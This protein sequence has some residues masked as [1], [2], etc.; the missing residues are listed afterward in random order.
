[1]G[2]VKQAWADR[3]EP[4]MPEPAFLYWVIRRT[5]TKTGAVDWLVGDDTFSAE[6]HLREEFSSREDAWSRLWQLRST[7]PAYRLTR[8]RA[9]VDATYILHVVPCRRRRR[10]RVA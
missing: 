9:P 7:Y 2:A 6:W 10:Q 4:E 1:M 3:Q 8:Q 5:D